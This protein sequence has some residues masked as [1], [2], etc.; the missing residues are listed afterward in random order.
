MK[1]H[2][3]LNGHA[4]ETEVQPGELLTEVL[5]RSGCLSVKRGCETGECGSCSILMDGRRVPSC[6]ILAAHADGAHIE[7]AEGLAEGKD[8]HP[9]QA[10]FMETGA[11]QCGVLH[12]RH[13]PGG[14][15]PTGQ[16]KLPLPGTGSRCHGLGL[17]PL[18][19]LCQAGRSRVCAPRPSCAVNR[20]PR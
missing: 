17:L 12:A 13:A 9:I 20:F 3:N 15:G 11:I 8:L 18:H 7:T 19:R 16:G 1:I 6:V 4:L 14:Q 10:A 2:F 5:R